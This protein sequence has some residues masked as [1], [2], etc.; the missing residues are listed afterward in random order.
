MAKKSR[1]RAQARA[2]KPVSGSVTV[3]PSAPAMTTPATA[4]APARHATDLAEEYRYVI[5]DLKRI[6]VLAAVMFALLVGL[7]VAAQ[8]LL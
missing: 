6:G 2:T 3:Q 5:G 8:Y 1:R 7:A 4:K